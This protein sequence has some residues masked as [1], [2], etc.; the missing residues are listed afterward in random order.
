MPRL[1]PAVQRLAVA[2]FS[3]AT[4]V[5]AGCSDS[6]SSPNRAISPE[7]A[8]AT[9][10][11]ELNDP[12]GHG[13]VFHTKQWF[14][15]D[16]KND[17]SHG[18]PGGNTGISYHGGPV[19]RAATAVA[20][21]YWG[22][23]PI[24]SNGPAVGT[25]GSGTSDASLVGYFLRNLGGSSYF[26]I[27][28]TYTDASRGRDRQRRQLHPVLG[29]RNECSVSGQNVSD[30]DMLAMLQS[31]FASNKLTYD[32]IDALRH[33]HRCPES[34]SAADLETS[35]AHTISWNRDRGWRDQDRPVRRDAIQLHVSGRLHQR[36]S[37]SER[38]SRRR[39]RGQYARPR[40]RRDDD[41]LD[42]Q[43][44]VRSARI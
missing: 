41:R 34:T 13:H 9:Q 19:L 25:S 14:E 8:N 15:N 2:G 40:N 37:R 16:A 29:E 4:V 3:V 1:L 38:R 23:S 27:N 10:S 24:F 35:I 32:A 26:K 5:L 39:C 11:P 43:C 21:V 7:A 12:N 6:T 30:A 17:A 18:K 42:G 33:L 20:A 31:A 36:D 22:S 44:V 28:T